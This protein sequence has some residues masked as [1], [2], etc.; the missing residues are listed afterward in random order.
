M[1]DKIVGTAMGMLKAQMAAANG[2]SI[3]VNLPE[4]LGISI[5]LAH[6]MTIQVKLP[7]SVDIV[8]G[9]QLG[10]SSKANTVEGELSS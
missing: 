9:L 5:R 3:R 7:E 1:L 8:V 10:E 2:L 4:G 6:G